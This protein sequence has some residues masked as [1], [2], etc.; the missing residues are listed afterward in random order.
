MDDKAL[1]RMVRHVD[2]QHREAMRTIHDDLGEAHLGTSD[3]AAMASRRAFL[4]RAGATG[5]VLAVGG[6]AVPLATTLPSAA[7]TATA[8]APE[9]NESDGEL[10][11]YA[12]SV[13]LAAVA[14]YQAA[15]DKRVLDSAATELARQFGRHHQEHADA[16]GTLI[17]KD[18][19]VS[20]PNPALVA[21]V[22][23]QMQA[24]QTTTAILQVAYDLETAAAATYQFAMG[25]I[26]NTTVS[27]AAASIEPVEA[28]HSVVLGQILEIDPT[29]W[30]PAF[31]SQT[32]ALSP[33][34][35]A[36]PS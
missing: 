9:L 24:A 26:I 21:A 13:E 19:V 10:V 1:R 18:M 11:R 29:E 15:V 27:G 22:S 20:A 32:G 12:Q 34:T 14:V 8:E 17:P 28:Q 33:Q 35:Y 31:Q 4:R 16:L 36:L 6:V 30:L 3:A 25:E 23:P 2:E 5:A 7:Q